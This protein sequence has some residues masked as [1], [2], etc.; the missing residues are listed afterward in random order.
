ML[1]FLTLTYTLHRVIYRK[2]IFSV[3]I[4]IT[5]CYI[6]LL[7]FCKGLSFL[8]IEKFKNTFKVFPIKYCIF[9]ENINIYIIIYNEKFK[10]KHWNKILNTLLRS[11][12]MELYMRK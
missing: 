8:F 9:F 11:R 12:Q 3:Y 2:I 4:F 10:Y 5:F 7:L 6:L 1:R